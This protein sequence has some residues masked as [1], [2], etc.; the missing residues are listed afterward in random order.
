MLCSVADVDDVE[1]ERALQFFVRG[2]VHDDFE[3]R[4][5][6][7]AQEARQI[8]THHQLLDAL[9]L[10]RDGTGF[11]IAGDG[12]H[13]DVPGGDGIGDLEFKGHRAVRIGE[14]VRLP[15]CGF[16]EVAAQFDGRWRVWCPASSLP[17]FLSI[18]LCATYRHIRADEGSRK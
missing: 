11:Q 8:R 16:A 7:F 5:I 15:E 17:T 4:L 6:S 18:S 3:F 12:V 1:I 13:P 9:C 2:V 10:A 14:K